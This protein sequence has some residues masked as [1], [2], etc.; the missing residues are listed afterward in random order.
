MVVCG[1][2]KRDYQGLIIV[3]GEI[4]ALA[5]MFL[6]ESRESLGAKLLRDGFS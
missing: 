1:P 2:F 5:A 4:F 3:L 6:A